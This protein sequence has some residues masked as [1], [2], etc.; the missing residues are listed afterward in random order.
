MRHNAS[1]FGDEG[2]R[3]LAES[4]SKFSYNQ[5]HCRCDAF[6]LRMV[7]IRASQWQGILEIE[8]EY[9]IAAHVVQTTGHRAMPFVHEFGRS[10]AHIEL[11]YSRN[12]Q[13][14]C[15][16]APFSLW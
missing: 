6:I 7:A 11:E 4:E 2:H 15:I 5:E 16:K 1:F 3:S 14:L 12:Q 8:R 10:L 9:L 13:T